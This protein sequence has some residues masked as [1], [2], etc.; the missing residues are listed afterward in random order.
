MEDDTKQTQ[1][2]DTWA[3]A[4]RVAKILSGVLIPLI[5][6]WIGWIIHE[7]STNAEFLKQSVAEL[8]KKDT[9]PALRDWAVDV[10]VKTSPVPVGPELQ[11]ALRQGKIYLQETSG[12]ANGSSPDF[13]GADLS[14]Q[15]LS[16]LDL[17]RANLSR[18]NLTQANLSRSFLSEAL[19][20]GSR[21][22][23]A[24]LRE[25]DLRDAVLDFADLRGA[26]LAGA[27]IRHASLTGANLSGVDLR[28]VHGLEVDQ[29]VESTLE[30]SPTAYSGVKNVGKPLARWDENTRFPEAVQ[31]QLVELGLV[32][33]NAHP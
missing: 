31:R 30:I 20:N 2:A 3:K 12:V 27:N 23:E 26:K 1:P 17:S 6:V 9:E 10:F 8:S 18:S 11:R 4:E 21:L 29:L 33:E 32:N 15:N 28:A 16:G 7:S 24:E 14:R 13:S 25:A 22:N 19:L 5:G